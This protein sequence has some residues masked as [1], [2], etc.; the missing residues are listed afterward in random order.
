[1]GNA[2]NQEQGD[3]GEQ[4]AD[5]D[6]HLVHRE[7]KLIVELFLGVDKVFIAII[8]QALFAL[9]KVG[10]LPGEFCLLTAEIYTLSLHDALP[11]CL[12]GG[13]GGFAPGK[14]GFRGG[15]WHGEYLLQENLLP[16]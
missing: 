9:L 2:Q 8:E 10:F 15:V 7:G 14:I 4:H 13:K 6:V 5:D 11:I 1:M 12:A 3:E 16:L